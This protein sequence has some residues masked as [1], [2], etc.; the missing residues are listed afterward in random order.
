VNARR[1]G[2]R[3]LE[4]DVLI[5]YYVHA[6]FPDGSPDSYSLFTLFESSP[7]KS[8]LVLIYAN[9]WMILGKIVFSIDFEEI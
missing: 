7:P 6:M 5:Y 8:K 1:E 9:C 3:A 2:D 4:L